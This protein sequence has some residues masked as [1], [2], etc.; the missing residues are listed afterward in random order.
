MQLALH[1]SQPVRQRG[2]GC[3]ANI[4][5][6]SEPFPQCSLSATTAA[7]RLHTCHHDNRLLPISCSRTGII[8]TW[9]LRY[10]IIIRKKNVYS[11]NTHF[12][13]RLLGMELCF[14]NFSVH[15]FLSLFISFLLSLSLSLLSLSLFL[16]L[17]FFLSLSLY[18]YLYLFLSFSLFLSVSLCCSVRGRR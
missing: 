5:H 9:Q 11:Y 16:S 12:F 1:N 2:L 4:L 14:A 17:F 18:F 13:C 8:I 6:Q 3:L 7:L 10:F 15:L